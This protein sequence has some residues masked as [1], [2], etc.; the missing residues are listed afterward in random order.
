MASAVAQL[1]SQQAAGRLTRTPPPRRPQ[2]HRIMYPWHVKAPV[3]ND[4]FI[5]GTPDCLAVGGQVSG[6]W[7]VHLCGG[8]TLARG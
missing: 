7:P 6:G 1:D 4:Y 2:P 8:A 3:K 5:Y